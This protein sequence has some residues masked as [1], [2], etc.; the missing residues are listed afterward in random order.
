MRIR[1]YRQGLGD[2][3]LL[4]VPKK[5]GDVVHV[6]I[7]CGVVLGTKDPA[8]IMTK[9]A[10]SLRKETGGG[11]KR[12]KIDVLV[13]THEHWDHLSGFTQAQNE[14]DQ[15]DFGQL[16]MAWTE[17]S[18]N[19]LAGALREERELKK[20]AAAETRAKLKKQKVNAGR[21]RRMDSLL[22]FYGMAA[23]GDGEG[24][25]GAGG[26][27]G[28]LDYLKAKVKKLR[29]LKP[30]DG[31]LEIP[32]VEGVRIYV[33]GPPEDKAKLHK[34]NPGKSQGYGLSGKDM[35]LA[36]AFS[37][38]LGINGD[39]QAERAQPFG[40]DFRQLQGNS[41]VANSLVGASY[42]SPDEAW[43]RIDEDWLAVGERLA[44]QLDNDTNN[45]SLVLAF[46]F[47]E[48]GEVL[49][50]VGDAQAGNW[51]SWDECKWRVKDKSGDQQEITA[52]DLL[53][54]TIFYKVGHHGSHNATLREKGLE[55]MTQPNLVAMM[56]VDEK[57]AHE[58]KGWMHMPLP[59]LC[60]RLK[61]KCVAFARTDEDKI[62]GDE[63]AGLG[64]FGNELFFDY[65]L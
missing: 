37:A 52:T 34:T 16:W 62:S 23:A 33:L 64:L 63:K 44:L 2:C 50:F 41:L 57:V 54:R 25:A 45:T 1:M 17:D 49:L 53:N 6:M 38:A 48:T 60:T 59:A 28:A 9:V 5:S 20:K 35:N 18:K 65:F 39:A 24:G 26:T 29:T 36:E 61:E 7:D 12:G 32:D 21:V 15:I 27:K 31:P 43:R 47:I 4:T 55:R 14:F 8:S 11:G 22:G 19:E 3:F 30:G 10:Q 42:L 13:I 56:P 58:T 51:L 46:E 40:M